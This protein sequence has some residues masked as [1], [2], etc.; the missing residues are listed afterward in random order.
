M[1][2]V[3]AVKKGGKIAIACDT[4]IKWGDEKNTAAH[5][6]NHNKIIKISDS[7]LAVTG[8]AAGILAMRHYFKHTKNK[9]SFKNVD[10][11]FITFKDIQAAFKESYG[12][13]VKSE[14]T[15]FEPNSMY[16]L[17]ANKHGIFA[18][19]SYRDIQEF[20]SF[21]AYGSGNEYALG[22]MSTI[23][24]HK[25]SAEEIAKIGIKAA[26]EFDSGTALPLISYV[27]DEKK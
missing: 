24:D 3:T 26:A 7:Y 17:I 12:F 6:V 10:D 11:I 1:S 2:T 15:G 4:L 16:I 21:Y 22:A 5:V 9:F 8:P 20:K 14:D 27:I 19:G 18:V 23:Y 25:L 13:E